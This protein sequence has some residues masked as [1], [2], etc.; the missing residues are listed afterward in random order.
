MIWLSVVI[1][2]YNESGRLPATLQRID[3]Y[4]SQRDGAFE[5]IVV[6]DGSEDDTVGAARSGGAV[7]VELPMN[8]GKGA[9]VRAGIARSQGSYVLISDA[10]LASPI[11]ELERLEAHRHEAQLVYG[12]RATSDSRIEQRQPWYREFLGK[13]FNKII[14]VFGVQG[15]AD[16]QCGFKLIEGDVARQIFG[17]MKLDGFAYDVELTWLANR[18][19]YRI[20]EVGVRWQ[21]V[22][23]S[24]V[25]L[26]LDPLKMFWDVAR[27]R[28][29]H[30]GLSAVEAHETRT[31]KG[32]VD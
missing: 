28:F 22:E 32:T 25:R 4:L 1:P 20:A 27:F 17:L 29:L 23:A 12:S 10:D 2:A 7:V 21:H 15:V 6:D 18:L 24:R 3:Q 19:G 8:Q 11:E 9:A 14:H 31:K 30:R 5:I 16:T 13:T 26:F